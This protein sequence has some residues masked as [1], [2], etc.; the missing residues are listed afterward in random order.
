MNEGDSM[1]VV[2]SGSEASCNEP[3]DLS[4]ILVHHGDFDPHLGIVKLQ[5]EGARTETVDL[6]GDSR[7]LVDS[8]Q[9][10]VGAITKHSVI[11]QG[12]GWTKA[13]EE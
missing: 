7:E 10:E 1:V 8:I 11:A 4:D 5:W 6:V 12:R 9:E 2:A 3:V 13:T